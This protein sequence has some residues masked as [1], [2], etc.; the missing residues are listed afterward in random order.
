MGDRTTSF[1][2]DIF[3]DDRVNDLLE[4][5][6]ELESEFNKEAQRDE[7]EK[8]T[9][10]REES[11]SGETKGDQSRSEHSPQEDSSKDQGGLTY[12]FTLDEDR[13][14]DRQDQERA[15]EWDTGREP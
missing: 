3:L 2:K 4:R 11:G 1:S 5:A 13:D 14:N 9:E 12:E 6:G 8:G 15:D 7:R 10:V